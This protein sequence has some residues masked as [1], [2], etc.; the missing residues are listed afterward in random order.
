VAA[1]D[2]SNSKR[3]DY[4]VDE[5]FPM[6]STFKFLAAAAVLRRVDEKQEKLERFVPYD[7]KQILEYAPVTKD[8]LKE[9]VMT[10]GALCA[11]AIEQSDD[12][13]ANLLL[14]T[15][16]DPA[17]LTNF[18]RGLGDNMTRLDRKEPELNSAIPGDDRDTTTP[19]R[20]AGHAAAIARR[21]F[22]K[23]VTP[24]ARRVV[25]AQ[26][27]RRTHDPLRSSKNADRRR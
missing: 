6:C 15:I 17:G 10:L 16:G 7:V 12:T 19:A 22:I 13:A 9:G 18:L 24:S 21:C 27:D 23:V 8:H 4:R 1:L 3:V 26:R 25:A 2:T 14:D 11:A 20:S 5:Q